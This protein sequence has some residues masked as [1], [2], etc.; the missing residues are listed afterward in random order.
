MSVDGYI[1]DTTDRRL[2]LSDAADLDR[3]D[4]E[5]AGCDAIL[6]GAG[7]LR[8]DD[9][10]L[11]V[12]PARQAQRQARGLPGDPV[13]VI[14][15]RTGEL[16]PAGRLW[17]EGGTRLVYAPPAGAAVARVRLGGLADVVALPDPPDVPA[18]RLPDLPAGRLAELVALL[19]DLAR[20]GVARLMVEGG[21]S[22]HTQ[23]LAAGLVDELH[24]VVAPFLVGDPAAPRFVGPAAFPQDATHRMTLAEVRPIG[25][26]A[27]LRYLPARSGPPPPPPGA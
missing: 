7:T 9:P 3:V 4:A 21:T 14:L 23:F 25:D 16:D 22:V 12:G 2:M 24:L 20:R 26:L 18:G 17:R 27:L 5:R 10:R 15:T 1:D 11:R 6:I 8:R 19:A 13:R